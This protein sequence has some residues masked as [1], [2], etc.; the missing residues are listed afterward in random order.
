M[1]TATETKTV[2]GEYS[3]TTETDGKIVEHAWWLKKNGKSE[4]TIEGRVKL[5]KTLVKTRRKL[6]DPETIKDTIAKQH[7][8]QRQ[9]KQC[10]Q[11]LTHHI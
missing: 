7:L 4:S 10:H 5:L 8:V 3:R 6:Y 1:E 11:M 2:A 9:K